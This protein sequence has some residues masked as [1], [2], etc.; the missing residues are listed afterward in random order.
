MIYLSILYNATRK[1]NFRPTEAGRKRRQSR[2]CFLSALFG[3]VLL[4]ISH[5]PAFSAITEQALS[6]KTESEQTETKSKQTRTEQAI[7]VQTMTEQALADFVRQEMQAEVDAYARQHHWQNVQTDIVITV[8]AAVQHLPVCP[9]PLTIAASD[10]N[11]QPVGNLKRQVR[12]DGGAHPWRINTTVKVEVQLPVVVARTAL[13]RGTKLAADMLKMQVMRF[14]RAT[15][16]A[17]QIPNVTGKRTER[18]IRSGQVIRPASLQQR[19]LVE[20]G[21]EVLITARKDGMQAST[22][23]IALEDGGKNEQIEVK[24]SRSEK[25]IKVR[26]T[27]YGKVETVF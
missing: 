13:N 7:A 5:P 23:G 18:R 26:V 22:R 14:N 21:D 27:D 6:K 8:P 1:R 11:N 24:N 19:W 4:G 12:C 2:I 10:L 16:F 20:T 25:V 15:D 17:T 3:S 9:E